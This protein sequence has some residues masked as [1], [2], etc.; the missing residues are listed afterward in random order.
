MTDLQTIPAAG[1]PIVL[2]ITKQALGKLKKKYAVVP[3]MN[4]K[5]GL[6]EFKKMNAECTPI[7]TGCDAEAKIQ[8][9]AAQKHI[10]SINSVLNVIVETMKKIERPWREAKK[11]VENA[12]AKRKQD[13]QDKED[14]RTAEIESKI[15]TIQSLTE[16]LLGADAEAIQA[17]L[18][19][20]D[21]II[22]DEAGY[23]LHIDAAITVMAQSVSQLKV[24]LSSAKVLE[25]GQAALKAQQEEMAEAQRKTEEA[26]AESQRQIE[27]QQAAAQKKIDDQQKVIDDQVA[28]QA[29]IDRQA[30]LAN[31]AK[32]REA[33][34]KARLPED[35]KMRKYAVSLLEV[36]P[37]DVESP[38]MVVLLR[39]ICLALA[40]IKG[41]VMS[42]TQEV[43]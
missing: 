28:A 10:K 16:G 29:E 43:K 14:A 9:D 37:P 20:A 33:E 17:R 7:R 11:T 31:E 4:T 2:G 39:D 30:K 32:E 25:E 13:L 3:D 23:D 18:D 6:A 41:A 15:E 38:E 12:E 21:K 1:T 8:K 26:N 40:D 24:A 34:L 19:T 35:V 5:E 27:E 36:A 22:I 42:G